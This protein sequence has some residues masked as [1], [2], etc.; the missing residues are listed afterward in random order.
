MFVRSLYVFCMLLGNI[1]GVTHVQKNKQSP[2]HEQA[3]AI[4]MQGAHINHFN[5]LCPQEKVFLHFDN[6]A[7]F[8]S[9]TIWF[10]ATVLDATTGSVAASKVLYVELLSPTGVVLRQQKLQV[11]DGR[12]HG[13]LPLVDASEGEYVDFEE[14][15]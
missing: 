4:L 14:I 10:S 12:C 7:Y 6:T 8:Q 11:I 5:R 13:S 3:Q 15:P 2:L 9:E 1:A